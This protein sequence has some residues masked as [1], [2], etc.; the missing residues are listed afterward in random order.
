MI[1]VPD[2]SFRLAE[3]QAASTCLQLALRL[4]IA[5]M[6][7]DV[8][9]LA[10]LIGGSKAKRVEIAD[11]IGFSEQYL[12]QIANGIKL[13]SGKPRVIGREL[14][15]ALDLAYPGWRNA[16]TTTISPPCVLRKPPK[17]HEAL[18]ALGIALAVDLPH[19]V[20][21]DLADALAKLARRKG[22]SRD[23]DLVLQL[24]TGPHSKRTGTAG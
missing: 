24:L 3:R 22:A 5:N 8:Q 19:D 17:L 4:S 23:Q 12:Y 7:T 2:S 11:H 10:R 21:E 1:M 16:E 13:K 18:E 20:R 6:D 14:R 15:E 9:A